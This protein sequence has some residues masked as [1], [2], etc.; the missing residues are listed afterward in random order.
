VTAAKQEVVPKGSEFLYER[1]HFAP[2]IRSGEWIFCSGDLG[3]DVGGGVPD[4]PGQQFTNVFES[5]SRTLEAAGA[6]LADVVEM[7][8]Y[9][10]GLQEHLRTFMEVKDRFVPKPYPA[11]TAIGVSELAIAGALVE[12]KVVARA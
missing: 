9:H 4:D 7:T 2:A 3:G 10:V 11:W 6:S 1:L 12:V 8:S 5:L